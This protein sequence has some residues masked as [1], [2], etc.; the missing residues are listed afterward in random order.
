MNMK[1][2]I[3]KIHNDMHMKKALDI[4][5]DGYRYK[6][7]YPDGSVKWDYRCNSDF[8]RFVDKYI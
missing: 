8:K 3:L 6:I 5:I 1:E 7:V 2:Y 4:I